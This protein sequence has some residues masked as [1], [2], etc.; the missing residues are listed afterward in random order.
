M[1]E[2]AAD[3]LAAGLDDPMAVDK[4]VLVALGFDAFRD[5]HRGPAQMPPQAPLERAAGALREPAPQRLHRLRLGR[6]LCL[7]ARVHAGCGAPLQLSL[8]RVLMHLRRQQDRFRAAVAAGGHPPLP[9]VRGQQR[10]RLC[11]PPGAVHKAPV[12]PVG[13]A[14]VAVL[15]RVRNQER[16]ATLEGEHP[17]TRALLALPGLRWVPRVAH[18]LRELHADEEALSLLPVRAVAA[19]NLRAPVN[20]SQRGLDKN[21][22]VML[23]RGAKYVD[24]NVP[25]LGP[26][27][28]LSA[29]VERLR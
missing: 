15:R 28:G 18:R 7:H 1:P 14:G 11:G 21:A 25:G 26:P 29:D 17:L 3:F 22:R 8:E 20:H 6:L 12:C 2:P 4:A 27:E 5:D 9:V 24:R 13:K 16:V 23:K 10:G 19:C